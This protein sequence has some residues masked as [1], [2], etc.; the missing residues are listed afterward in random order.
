MPWL[1]LTRS[2]AQSEE[3]QALK[4]QLELYVLRAQDTGPGVQ[5]P[6]A[7]RDAARRRRPAA[8]T[9]GRRAAQRSRS[10]RR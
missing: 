2:T 1:R 3:D 7:G 4:E 5:K 9:R 6:M 8:G 10:W